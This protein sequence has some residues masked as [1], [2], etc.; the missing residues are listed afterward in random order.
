MEVWPSAG[1]RDRRAMVL[2]AVLAS[3]GAV[4]LTGTPAEPCDCRRLPEPSPGIATEAKFIFIGRVFEVR[5]R[6]EHLIITRETSA[7]TSVRPLERSVIFQ[8]SRAWRGVTSKTF[9]VNTDWSDCMYPFEAGSDYLVFA[10]IA[11]RGR[12]YTSTCYRTTPADR[13]ERLLKLLQGPL[14]GLPDGL[15]PRQ[16]LAENSLGEHGVTAQGLTAEARLLAQPVSFELVSTTH[17][18]GIEDRIT[19][20]PLAARRLQDSFQE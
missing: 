19:M 12:P 4:L 15:A 17:A 3:A 2:L 10:D 20:A 8:L 6:S 1:W 5:E 11:D 7:E 14:T 13:A 18:E 9:T 16:G